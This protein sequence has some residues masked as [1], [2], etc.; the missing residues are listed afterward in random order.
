[1][2]MCGCVYIK[3]NVGNI[4]LP[5][6]L[7]PCLLELWESRLLETFTPHVVELLLSCLRLLVAGEQIVNNHVEK[8]ATKSSSTAKD[9]QSSAS[10]GPLHH[11]SSTLPVT[12]RVDAVSLQQVNIMYK[13]N[14][15]S[16]M[17][18]LAVHIYS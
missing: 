10:V 16:I 2:Y 13:C 1:M 11:A 7:A 14:D 17:N 15:Y 8:K 18:V 4:L 12:G 6:C 5:Q 3:S 9:G